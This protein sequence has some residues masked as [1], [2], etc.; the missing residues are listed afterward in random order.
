MYHAMCIVCLLV[1]DGRGPGVLSYQTYVSKGWGHG[2]FCL[3]HVDA[4]R[5]HEASVDS[6]YR[7]V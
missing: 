3:P 6:F 2:T 1:S 7:L 4:N 5:D